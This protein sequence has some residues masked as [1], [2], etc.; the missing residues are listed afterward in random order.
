MVKEQYPK[1]MLCDLCNTCD[2]YFSANSGSM[3]GVGNEYVCSGIIIRPKD[4]KDTH[5]RF[6]RIRL[7]VCKNGLDFDAGFDTKEMTE[8]EAADIIS[9]L[10]SCLSASLNRLQPTT[11]QIMDFELVQLRKEVEKDG[12]ES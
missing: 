6:N 9:V 2:I 5:E 3:D 11:K 8:L 7:C 10:G 1:Q 12:I 4:P